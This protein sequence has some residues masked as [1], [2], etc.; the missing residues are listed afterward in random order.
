MLV[1]VR[2]RRRARARTTARTRA[3]I[4]RVCRVR[5][6]HVRATM[7]HGVPIK[8]IIHHLMYD[9]SGRRKASQD[10]RHWALRSRR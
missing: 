2:R 4:S 7:L 3:R 6:I 5:V 1:R 10:D 8:G 9:E